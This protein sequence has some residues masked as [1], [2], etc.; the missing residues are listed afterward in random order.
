MLAPVAATICLQDTSGS[1][2][3]HCFTIFLAAISG[4]LIGSLALLLSPFLSSW[5]VLSL[6]SLVFLYP[7]LAALFVKIAWGFFV[8]SATS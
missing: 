4:A 1:T 7:S 5:I 2:Y 3:K 8:L 6:G